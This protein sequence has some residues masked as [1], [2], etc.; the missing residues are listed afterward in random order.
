M[1]L[2]APNQAGRR[3]LLEALDWFSKQPDYSFDNEY[4]KYLGRF[5]TVEGVAY[6]FAG[7]QK[8]PEDVLPVTMAIR[9][10]GDKVFLD[11]DYWHYIY[12]RLVCG[13]VNSSEPETNNQ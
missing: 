6:R 2:H 3:T 9:E 5:F 4:G 8:T 1:Y 12:G 13:P 11:A 10:D 7:A